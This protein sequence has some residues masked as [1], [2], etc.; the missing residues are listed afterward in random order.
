[1]EIFSS[2]NLKT[3]KAEKRLILKMQADKVEFEKLFGGGFSDEGRASI[4]EG[5][6]KL[7]T[8]RLEYFKNQG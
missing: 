6:I 1:M 5:L 3:T 4:L 7:N 8:E 2:E